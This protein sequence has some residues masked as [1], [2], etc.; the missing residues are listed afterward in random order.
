M[1]KFVGMF[2]AGALAV[3]YLLAADASAP[4]ID[5]AK[6]QSYV[7]YVEAYTAEVKLAVDD[8][9]PSAYPGYY[10]VVV[11]AALGT[12]K[13]GDRLYY[14]ADGQH[15]SGGALWD[16]SQNPFADTL[17]RLPTD[18]PSFGP[19]N[20]KFT[21]VIFSDFEC[22]YCRE[23]AKTIRTNIPQ[24]YP[25]DVRI[26]FKDFPIPSIHPWAVAA[27]EAGECLAREKPAAFWAFH[28]WIFEHQQEVNASNIKEKTLVIAK[29]QAVDEAKVGACID[30]H[31]TQ[32]QV[33]E[34]M[35]AGRALQIEQTPTTFL[36]G[37]MVPGAL[38]W[39]ALDALLRFESN[40]PKDIPAAPAAKC[41]QVTIPTVLNKGAR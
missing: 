5:N 18:G 32:A 40:R 25:N 2:V 10:R 37:R 28:D 16:L 33:E 36:N 14:T 30:T 6:L 34:S 3:T 7:R 27:S 41:C 23:F 9:V 17:A 15:F 11:H 20:A 1:L 29:E 22:P 24:K 26:V 35:R 4:K 21:M 39:S 12:Q 31:A 19:E 8:P 13:V 38:P